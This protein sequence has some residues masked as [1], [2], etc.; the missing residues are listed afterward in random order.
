MNTPSQSDRGFATAELRQTMV[1]CQLRTFDVTDHGV[2]ARMADVPRELFLPE[3]LISVAYSDKAI[4]LTAG[5]TRRRLLAPMV[6][7][8]MLQGADITDDANVLCIGGGSGYGAAIVAG[9]A[10]RVIALESDGSFSNMAE[11]G[12]LTLDISNVQAIT[13]NLVAGYASAGPF[14]VIIIEGAVETTPSNLL[15]QL[16][17][18]GCLVCIEAQ[19]GAAQAGAGRAVRYQKSAGAMGRQYLFSCAAATLPEFARAAEFSF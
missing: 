15:G 1:D 2:L 9:L 16:A 11:A 3:N 10:K 14:D 8:R 6:L 7:A 13:G 18:G 19:A 17:E 4:E 12:L 5:S